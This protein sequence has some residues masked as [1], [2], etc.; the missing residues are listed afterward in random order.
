MQQL[1]VRVTRDEHRAMKRLA[2]TR[3]TTIVAIVRE[4][5]RRVTRDK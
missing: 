5:I 1:I 3:K 4:W 2:R